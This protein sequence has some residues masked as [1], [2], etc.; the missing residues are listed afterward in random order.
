MSARKAWTPESTRRKLTPPEVAELWGISLNSIMTWIRNGELR[1]INVAKIVG[2]RPRY[3]I[4][5]DDLENFERRRAVQ[6]P[7]PRS[8]RRRK[9]D[10]LFRYF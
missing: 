8:P 1:A 6:P 4:D 2:G 5:V 3:R 7:P 10:Y 9:T